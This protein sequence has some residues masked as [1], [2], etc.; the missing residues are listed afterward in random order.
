MTTRTADAV[1]LATG[2]PAPSTRPTFTDGRWIAFGKQDPRHFAVALL[3]AAALDLPAVPP[4]P[5]SAV[6]RIAAKTEHVT[7]RCADA[8]TAERHGLPWLVMVDGD[9]ERYQEAPV[10]WSEPIT[11]TVWSPFK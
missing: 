7:V 4:G 3:A 9:H 8:K 10:S 2:H 5:G 11:V 6:E 1:I